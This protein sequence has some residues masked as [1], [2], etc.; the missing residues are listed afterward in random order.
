MATIESFILTL[1]LYNLRM[2]SQRCFTKDGSQIF[3][4]I[5]VITEKELELSL[6]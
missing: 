4:G 3:T 6:M 5:F 1:N 2:T